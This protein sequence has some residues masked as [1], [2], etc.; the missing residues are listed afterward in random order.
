MKYPWLGASPDFLVIDNSTEMP[1]GIG[2]IKFPDS[3][4]DVSIDESCKGPVTIYTQGWGRRE[5]VFELKKY[6]YPTINNQ[7]FSKTPPFISLKNTY[8]TFA[9]TFVIQPI[10]SSP[11][12]GILV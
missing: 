2:E 5:N 3:K 10:F 4:K 7:K 11:L 1:F 12:L 9:N 6:I 8:P